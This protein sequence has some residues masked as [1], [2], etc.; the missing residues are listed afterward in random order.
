[1]KKY[2]IATCINCY[3][4]ELPTTIRQAP[5]PAG[6]IGGSFKNSYSGTRSRSAFAG[7]L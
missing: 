4:F 5:S 2:Q 3:L 1:M 6:V 7:L